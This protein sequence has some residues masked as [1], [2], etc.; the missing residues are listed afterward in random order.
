V[1]IVDAVLYRSKPCAPGR[2]VQSCGS[3]KAIRWF[4]SDACVSR[5][6]A[7]S[8]TAVDVAAR[9]SRR[10][11]RRHRDRVEGSRGCDGNLRA[12]NRSVVLHRA[13]KV[14][15]L[16]DFSDEARPTAFPARR[17]IPR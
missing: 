4:Q 12:V 13:R 3:S 11:L 16:L 15:T 6:K 9:R 8:S 2:Q 1:I 10:R 7:V 17:S 5:P 14:E